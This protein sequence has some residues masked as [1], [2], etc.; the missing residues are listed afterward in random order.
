VDFTII[1]N[2]DDG[3]GKNALPSSEWSR[4]VEKLKSSRNVQLLGYVKIGYGKRSISTVTGQ[5]NKY[6]GWASK[7]RSIAV[8]GIFIDE[9]PYNWNETTSKYLGD[10]KRAVKDS[11]GLGRRLI[12][13]TSC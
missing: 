10:V 3:P 4:G 9:A 6:A 13:K 1:L 11:S 5:I 12:S 2:P 7:K 8:D